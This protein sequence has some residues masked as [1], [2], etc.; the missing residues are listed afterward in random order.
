LRRLAVGEEA[1]GDGQQIRLRRCERNCVSWR[2]SFVLVFEALLF[3]PQ[4]KKRHAEKMV[5]I[6]AV[7]NQGFRDL[8]TNCR[9]FCGGAG[10]SS[11][12]TSTLLEHGL[13]DAV[14]LV[15]YPIQLGPGKRFFAEGTPARSLELLSTKQRR[16]VSS[17]VI[18]RWPG[19]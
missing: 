7:E 1:G 18:T 15:V 14:L 5:L 13:A 10:G 19:L 17:S 6:G 2:F 3:R 16:P 11:T 8:D 9:I 12:L 4:P